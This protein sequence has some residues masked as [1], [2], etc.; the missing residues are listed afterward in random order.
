MQ[1]PVFQDESRGIIPMRQKKSSN[2]CSAGRWPSRQ[3]KPHDPV[4]A[5]IR[6]PDM[7]FRVNGDARR[8]AERCSIDSIITP[9]LNQLTICGVF[10]Y[11][12]AFWIGNEY[13][14]FV[15]YCNERF[16]VRRPTYPPDDIP[17]F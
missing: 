15:V 16:V 1:I 4:I 13:M 2:S 9:C 12:I 8:H 10:D 3:C 14:A 5:C 6:N 11:A 7:A 17:L